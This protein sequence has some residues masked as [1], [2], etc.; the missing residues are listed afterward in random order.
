MG[1]QIR[2]SE[3]ACGASD[4]TVLGGSYVIIFVASDNAFTLL[5]WESLILLSLVFIPVRM[6]MHQF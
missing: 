2:C 6:F 4:I 3:H 1:L 5:P